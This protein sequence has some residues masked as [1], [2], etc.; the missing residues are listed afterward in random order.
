[1]RRILVGTSLAL[2]ASFGWFTPEAEAQYL[3]LCSWT[4]TCASAYARYENGTLYVT[5]R[6]VSLDDYGY[7]D[8]TSWIGPADSRS[9]VI[10]GVNLQIDGIQSL[11]SS[12]FRAYAGTNATGTDIT[13]YWNVR[14]DGEFRQF[15]LDF[16]FGVT[17]DGCGGIIRSG[18]T[19][20]LPCGP[21]GNFWTAVTFA[22]DVTPASGE[23][24][25]MEYFAAQLR[26]I[27]YA[28]CYAGDTADPFC[29]SGIATVPEPVT[30]LLLGTG[31]AGLGGAGIL[32]RRRRNSGDVGDG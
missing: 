15:G 8:G 30:M 18:D 12:G 31:L 20:D 2:V 1:M 25:S 32:R 29:E 6:N 23:Q 7:F 11:S 24:P 16:N 28:T 17:R 13:Q 9:S 3:S 26:H 5:V 19:P 4:T 21:N 22:I 10:A 27:D 14:N